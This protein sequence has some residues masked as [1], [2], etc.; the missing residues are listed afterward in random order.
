MRNLTTSHWSALALVSPRHLRFAGNRPTAWF[1]LWPSWG[2]YASSAER[3]TLLVHRREIDRL[4]DDLRR[5]VLP[6]DDPLDA[7]M[8][9][10]LDRWALEALGAPIYP[11]SRYQLGVAEAVIARYQLG[12]R[13]RVIRWGLA[14]RFTGKRRQDVPISSALPDGDT[15]LR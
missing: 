3:V 1:D 10:R 8:T 5:F 2:L 13:A 14:N 6:A 9:L 4:P 7:W 15:Q 11:Q 12:H